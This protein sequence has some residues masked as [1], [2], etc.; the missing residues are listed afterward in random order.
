MS[1]VDDLIAAWKDA[2]AAEKAANQAR[3]EAEERINEHFGILTS[4]ALKLDGIT[5]N[6]GLERKWDQAKLTE[7]R[8]TVKTE[9]WPFRIE[10]KEDK[11][12]SDYI[13]NKFPGLWDEIKTALT[14]K[15]KKPS[16]SI[17]E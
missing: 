5:V 6:Y 4:G 3:L 10:W 7:L 12:A 9:Y 2:K 8:P 14:T 11:K 17:K 13:E 15:P 1:E 16:F